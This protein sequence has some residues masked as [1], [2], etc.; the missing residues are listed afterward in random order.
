LHSRDQ[1]SRYRL[2][3]IKPSHPATRSERQAQKRLLIAPNSLRQTCALRRTPAAMAAGVV[4]NLWSFE[5][6][7]D[8][9]TAA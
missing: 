4:N 1:W 3:P 5:R 8:E 2:S 7:Y 6:M 9:M